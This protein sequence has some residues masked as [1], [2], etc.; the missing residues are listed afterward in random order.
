MECIISPVRRV[1]RSQSG[2]GHVRKFDNARK[3]LDCSAA[4]S[5]RVYVGVVGV[6]DV[7]VECRHQLRR[8]AIGKACACA[9]TNHGR[10]LGGLN[11]VA[12]DLLQWVGNGSGWKSKCVCVF[13]QSRSLEDDVVSVWRIRCGVCRARRHWRRNIIGMLNQLDGRQ[14]VGMM[15]GRS[16][17]ETAGER[18]DTERQQSQRTIAE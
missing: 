15:E 9:T 18:H 4:S 7:D 11:T 10:L 13:K 12:L 8:A 5:L 16:N 17:A 1:Q 14:G 3:E 2:Q 6:G